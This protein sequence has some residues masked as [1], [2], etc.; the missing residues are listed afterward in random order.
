MDT[1]PNTPESL[2][3]ES[4][5]IAQLKPFNH[6]ARLNFDCAVNTMQEHEHQ[7]RAA[8]IYVQRERVHGR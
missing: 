4:P 2:T 6:Q 5:I 7:S 1:I 8:S 3:P